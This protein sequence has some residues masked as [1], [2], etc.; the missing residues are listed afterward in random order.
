MELS[1]AD[2]LRPLSHGASYTY[3]NQFQ[4]QLVA[5][6]LLLD[7]TLTLVFLINI[8][9]NDLTVIIFEVLVEAVEA[10]PAVVGQLAVVDE[11]LKDPELLVAQLRRQ[12]E[13]QVE[14]ALALRQD[15]KQQMPWLNM[16]KN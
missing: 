1:A 14:Q 5:T 16:Q 4:R 13:D 3:P 7:L 8:A 9:I 11:R 15:L 12:V 2:K 10:V 6:R